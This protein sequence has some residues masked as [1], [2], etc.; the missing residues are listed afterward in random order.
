MKVENITSR[1]VVIG[2][3]AVGPGEI[4]TVSDEADVSP[5]LRNGLIKVYGAK[6]NELGTMT[7]KELR[8]IGDKVGA[9]DTKKSELIKEIIEKRGD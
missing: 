9:K 2:E 4:K 7:M 3:I 6:V 5:L 8:K 1:P